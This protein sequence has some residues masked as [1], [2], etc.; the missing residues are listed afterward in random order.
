MANTVFNIPNDLS[1]V[2]RSFDVDP[3]ADGVNIKSSSGYALSPVVQRSFT[4]R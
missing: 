2:I 4:Y 1:M 3:I